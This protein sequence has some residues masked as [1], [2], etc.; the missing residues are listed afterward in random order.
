MGGGSQRPPPPPFMFALTP[1]QALAK[2]GEKTVYG[3]RE[4]KQSLSFFKESTSVVY[5]WNYIISHILG[6]LAQVTDSDPQEAGPMKVQKPN[7]RGGTIC[8]DE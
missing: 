4:A 7:L 8:L 1:L 2:H 6:C 3:Q 5:C